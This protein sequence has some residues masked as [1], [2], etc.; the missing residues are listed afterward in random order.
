MRYE[1]LDEES[2]AS[3]GIFVR[4]LFHPA[5][6]D[7]TVEGVLHALSDPL[8][9]QIFAKIVSA[10]CPQTCSEFLEIRDKQV[11]KSTLSQHFKVLREAGLIR[12]ERKGVEMHNTPR[13]PELEGRFP[14]L[15]SAIL[16]AHMVQ[17]RQSQPAK[18]TRRKIVS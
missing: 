1:L 16:N 4:P 12:G 10:V 3:Y 2:N 13:C 11:P 17:C 14:G 8:R 9:V 5:A 18:K 7:I 15:V 6:N